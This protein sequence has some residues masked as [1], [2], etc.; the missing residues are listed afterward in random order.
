M[1]IY[2]EDYYRNY[3]I[4]LGQPVDYKTSEYTK[5]FLEGIAKRI[6][7]VYRPKVVLDAGCAMGHLVAALRDLGVEAYGIDVSEYA[8]SQVREDIRPY[9]VV[10]SLTEPLPKALPQ[11]FDL[12]T[13]IEVIEHL[14]EPDAPLAVANLCAVTDVVLFSS[15]PDDFTEPTHV[16]VQQREYWAKLFARNDFYD[17]LTNRPTFLTEYAICFRR[18]GNWIRQVEDYERN[19]RLEAKQTK[20]RNE[21]IALQNKQ[22]EKLNAQISDQQ[23]HHNQEVEELKAQACNRQDEHTQKMA[24]LEEALAEKEEQMRKLQVMLEEEQKR[25]LNLENELKEHSYNTNVLENDVKEKKG[26]LAGLT[27]KMQKIEDQNLSLRTENECLRGDATELNSQYELVLGQYMEVTNSTAW[28][29]TRPIRIV[30]DRIKGVLK[31]HGK[32]AVMYK[33]VV[34]LVKQGPRQF[35]RKLKAFLKKRELKKLD[36]RELKQLNPSVNDDLTGPKISILVPL[37]NTPEK[38]L[39]EMIESVQNQTYGNWELCLA[40]GSDD[41]H[42]NVGS[43][44]KKYVAGDARILYKKLE[45]NLGISGNTNECINM[46]TGEYISLFDHDDLL[47]PSALFEV[48]KAICEQN[49]D[50]I[51]TDEN[52]FHETPEDA[53][54]PHFKPNFAPDTLRSYNYICHF[55]TFERSLLKKAGGGFRTEFDGSQDYDM[56]LRLT[57]QAEH[58]VHIPKILYYW[59]SHPNS[60]ASDVSAKPYTI[61]SAKKALSQHLSRVGLKGTVLDSVIPSTYKIA[62]EIDGEPM[63]SI[64]IPNYE[65][66]D[67]LKTC[68]NS[69]YDKTTYRRFEIIIIENN[70]KTAEIFNYYEQIQKKWDNLKVVEWSGKFNYSAIN[71]F[72]AKY[73]NGDVLLLLNND[74]EVITPDWLEQMLMF[75]QRKDVGAV[76]AMLYY[77]DNTVQHAG[78]ILGIGGV[79]GHA[80][81]YFQRGD[82]GYMSRL[83]IAQNYSCV[84]AACVMMRRAVWNEIGGLDE[85]FE[86]AFNDVDMCMRI[87]KAGYLVVWTPYAELYHYES[88]SRGLEDT[89]EKQKRFQ[90]EVLRF[91]NRWEKELQAGDP[92]Y[93]PNLTLVREDF[94]VKV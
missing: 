90:E 63:I 8:I 67:S 3:D 48:V 89:P 1:E 12:V 62:Y 25:S 43:I 69:I 81:K 38:Y 65:N 23:N 66:I 85:S 54:C 55:T 50:F 2:N 33:G 29:I 14:Y 74:T 70:S 18:S 21:I 68:L 94:S 87:R 75:A 11:Y 76:G 26:Q 78:V 93:N 59:R 46:A 7:E 19:I 58:I 72:G 79:G 86:V 83:T 39:Q 10:G 61:V 71:N 27:E 49:A 5:T 77:P 9:C 4:G 64:L 47:H 53:F 16:N 82:Y 35:F 6:V 34:C 57:E 28:K 88:K 84:T 15:S 17:C 73:A 30:L 42:S 24:T 80:H 40:D 45:K 44:C 37:Y 51:Y 41:S 32:T 31:S 20:D 92:Y 22:I 13:N 91:Q 52:T 56:I 36:A 60:V